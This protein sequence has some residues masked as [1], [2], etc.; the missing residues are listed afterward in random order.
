[1]PSSVVIVLCLFSIG[2]A[3]VETLACPAVAVIVTA[4]TLAAAATPAPATR[5]LRRDVGIFKPPYA[6]VSPSLES[7]D[8]TLTRTVLPRRSAA[9]IVVTL[10]GPA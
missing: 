5:N 9:M 2:P 10:A 6:V 1:V 7:Q 4:G 8:R 3:E